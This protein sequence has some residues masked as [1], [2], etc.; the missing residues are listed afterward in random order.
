MAHG[1]APARFSAV[2]IALHW[3]IAALIVTNFVIGLRFDS[4]QGMALFDLMQWHKSFGITVLLLSLARLGWRLLNPPPARPLG[5]P[6]WERRAATLTHWGFYAL[7]IGLPLTGWIIVSASP[8]NIPT[9]LYKTVPWPHIGPIHDLPFA[10][11]KSIESGA[12][13]VH[14]WL[15]WGGAALFLLHVGA[16][17]RHQLFKRDGVLWT[18]VPLP[19]L[20]PR[21]SSSED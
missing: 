1:T 4:L 5:M 3:A 7:M 15:A 12:G 6:A 19:L 18:M 10:Q 20:R 17:L 2:A 9:L 11:R 14:E 16:A 13:G 21:T 8:F